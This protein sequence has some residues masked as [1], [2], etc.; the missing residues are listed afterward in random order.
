[1]R[2]YAKNHYEYAMLI[3]DNRRYLRIIQ[4]AFL[5]TINDYK[6]LLMAINIK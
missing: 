6:P 3:E 4:N 2:I 5:M 1:V